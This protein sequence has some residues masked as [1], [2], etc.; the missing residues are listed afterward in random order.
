MLSISP[1]HASDKGEQAPE[2]LEETRSPSKDK[3][4]PSEQEHTERV[5][6][7][8]TMHLHSESTHTRFNADKMG[9]SQLSLDKSAQDKNEDEDGTAIPPPLLK[10]CPEDNGE[11]MRSPSTLAKMAAAK[12]ITRQQRAAQEISS[13]PF[14]GWSRAKQKDQTGQWSDKNNQDLSSAPKRKGNKGALEETILF[15]LGTK[16]FKRGE[17]DNEEARCL[18]L[19][20]TIAQQD[21]F[22]G[23][24]EATGSVK[25]GDDPETLLAGPPHYRLQVKTAKVP[26]P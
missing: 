3:G 12:E 21:K 6:K 10:K 7:R 11:R 9:G 23:D 16:P 2:S 4:V 14:E 22:E 20:H 8:I 15:P 1:M 17:K 19:G 18:A 5:D 13:S 25:S 26:L 24:N